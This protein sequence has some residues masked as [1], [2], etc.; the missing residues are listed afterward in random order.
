MTLLVTGG[1]GF[2]GSYFTRYALEHGAKV[3]VL[4]RYPDRA[5]IADVLDQVTLVEGDVADPALVRSVIEDHGVDRVAHFAFILGS[6]AVGRMADY[7]AVQC[8][9][10]ATVLE[11]SRLAGVKRLVFASSVAA[12]GAQEAPVLTE[13]LRG[14]PVV[15]YGFCKSWAEALVRHYRREL[16][17]DGVS[18]RYGSTY[19]FGRAK[20]GSYASGM[21]AP[22]A[23]THYMARVEHAAAGK[24]ITMPADETMADFTYAEDA[25][26]AAWLAMTVEKPSYDLYN[27]SAERLPVGRFTAALRRVLPYASITV[28]ADE[29]AGHAHAPMNNRRLVEDLGFRPLFDLERGIEDYIERIGIAERYA[30]EIA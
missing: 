16:G 12:Y 17:L 4:E 29:G 2:L 13:D 24:A 26:Q 10:T 30:T 28:R 23:D 21:F 1:T 18:L 25:A 14:D 8:D 7:L 19:G 20:R 5:R 3:V 9:G 22:P 27:V 15:P 6:P 11:A